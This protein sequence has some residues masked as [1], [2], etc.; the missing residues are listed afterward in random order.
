MAVKSAVLPMRLVDSETERVLLANALSRPEFCKAVLPQLAPE[1]FAVERHRRVFSLMVDATAHGHEPGL[2]GAYRRLLDLGKTPGELGLPFLS[3][4]A[5][6]DTV[7]LATPGPWIASLKRKAAERATW[8]LAER[9][10]L[11]IECG[12]GTTEDLAS[13]RE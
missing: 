10:R 8:R 2:S 3:E 12:T 13:A 11:A 4:L 1:L 5:F 6:N 9:M 7:E